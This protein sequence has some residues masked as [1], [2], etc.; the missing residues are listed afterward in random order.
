MR[1]VLSV[2]CAF[3]CENTPSK[4]PILALFAKN[5]KTEY[6]NYNNINTL[7][8]CI[9]QFNLKR[10]IHKTIFVAI[11]KSINSDSLSEAV[12]ET[13]RMEYKSCANLCHTAERLLL[14]VTLLHQIFEILLGFDYIFGIVSAKLALYGHDALET[15]VGQCL[16]YTGEVH[17]ALGN[18]CLAAQSVGIGGVLAVLDVQLLEQRAKLIDGIHGIGLAIKDEVGGVAID[19]D[20][21]CADITDGTDKGGG[22]FLTRL[23]ENH[24]ASFL[25]IQT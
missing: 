12:T 15:D 24:H 20:V 11:Y 18:L 8:F 19:K 1:W 22:S 7:H 9:L 16:D 14:L 17:I 5:A 6:A 4:R 10:A 3:Q 25:G 21:A 13:N 2:L 23:A